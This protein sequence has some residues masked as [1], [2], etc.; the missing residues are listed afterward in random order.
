MLTFFTLRENFY[1]LRVSLIVD[2]DA[3]AA[4]LTVT[5]NRRIVRHEELPFADFAIGGKVA[6]LAKAQAWLHRPCGERGNFIEAL[7]YACRTG[8]LKRA[9][10]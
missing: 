3:K 2:G 7:E 8:A 4:S 1:D 5:Y 10:A 6:D 9:A